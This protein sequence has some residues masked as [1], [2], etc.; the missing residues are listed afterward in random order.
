MRGWTWIRGSDQRVLLSSNLE[1]ARLS[2]IHVFLPS[3]LRGPVVSSNLTARERHS[4]VRAS[5]TVSSD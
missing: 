2:K 1:K 4:M 5:T 3:V